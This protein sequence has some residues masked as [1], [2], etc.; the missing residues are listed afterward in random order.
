MRM[1]TSKKQGRPWSLI[2]RMWLSHPADL[3]LAGR[4]ANQTR[5]NRVPMVT[6]ADPGFDEGGLG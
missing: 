5:T 2:H 3:L 4:N 1:M 6:G